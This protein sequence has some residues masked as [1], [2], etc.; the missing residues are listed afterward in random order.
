MTRSNSQLGQGSVPV[1]IANLVK[2]VL[3]GVYKIRGDVALLMVAETQTIE[4]VTAS[5][6]YRSG[7]KVD[8]NGSWKVQYE[9]TKT[10]NL[11]GHMSVI[12]NNKL[13]TLDTSS[14]ISRSTMSGMMKD[15]WFGMQSTG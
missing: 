2:E 10:T 7:A 3:S 11:P 6:S 8:D 4:L 12:Y 1:V 15:S 5:G 14:L 9:D 13:N